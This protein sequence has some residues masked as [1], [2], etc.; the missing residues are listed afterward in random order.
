[1]GVDDNLKENLE[2]FFVMDYPIYELLFC[3]QDVNDPAINVVKN[4]IEQY[5]SIDAKLFC[6][7]KTVGINPK[8]NNM[9]QGYQVA[10]YE[11]MLI[12]DAGIRSILIKIRILFLKFFKIKWLMTHCTTW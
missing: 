11:L 8:I 9:E 3:V 6:G 2:T 7:G 4:L 5:P 10:K 12:S 1:M